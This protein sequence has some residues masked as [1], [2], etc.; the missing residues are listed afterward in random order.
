VVAISKL[1]A[2]IIGVEWPALLWFVEPSGGNAAVI[3]DALQ[4][5]ERSVVDIQVPSPGIQVP[6]LVA[7][8][9]LAR[10]GV[11]PTINVIEVSFFHAHTAE[12]T[13]L[14]YVRQNRE[15]LWCF[16]YCDD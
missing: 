4:A 12:G 7:R 16:E 2:D 8:R 10:A 11:V 9:Q 14:I 1:D 15:W 5:R 6:S 3:L 13:S